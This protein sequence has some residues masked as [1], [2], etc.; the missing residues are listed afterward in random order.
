MFCSFGN[1]RGILNSS[2][3]I[4]MEDPRWS[5]WIIT[6]SHLCKR[7]PLLGHLPLPYPPLY[8][9]VKYLPVILFYFFVLIFCCRSISYYIY[10]YVFEGNSKRPHHKFDKT[11]NHT[12]KLIIKIY[13]SYNNFLNRLLFWITVKLKRL[14][15]LQKQNI[16]LCN[17]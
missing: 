8:Q 6:D 1:I 11:L 3:W 9:P 10:S 7:D 13:F 14:A 4:M 2:S 16:S 5:S 17:H 15:D 12:I